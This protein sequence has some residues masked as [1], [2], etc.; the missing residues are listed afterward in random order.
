MRL[1]AAELR[2]GRHWRQGFSKLLLITQPT[3]LL[4]APWGSTALALLLVLHLP[5]A[6]ALAEAGIIIILVK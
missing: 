6:V 3:L 1:G 2:R 4:P 5:L